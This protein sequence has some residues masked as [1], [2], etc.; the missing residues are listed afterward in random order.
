MKSRC[1][2]SDFQT[3]IMIGAFIMQTLDAIFTRKTIRS[4]T[5]QAVEKEKLETIAQAG[6]Q[7]AI[8]GK[9]EFVVI[10]N[11]NILDQIQREAKAFFLRSGVEKL[12]MLASNPNYEVLHNAPAGI[13]VVTNTSNDPHIMRMNSANTGCAVQNM[14]IAATDLGLGSCYADSGAVAFSNPELKQ[15][16]GIPEDKTVSAIVTLGYS[17]DD[18]PAVK[19]STNN[20]TWCQ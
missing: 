5:D 10:T 18:T 1:Q 4:Y 8:A 14:L 19:R 11:R 2:S 15:A 12:V 13:A 20:I 7:A 17:A 6:N 3:F 16:I 9:L